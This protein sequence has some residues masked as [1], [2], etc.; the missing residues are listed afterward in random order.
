[1]ISGLVFGSLFYPIAGLEG[2]VFI[3][4]F[5]GLLDIDHLSWYWANKGFT[6][7]PNKIRKW[8]Y[9]N[10]PSIQHLMLHIPELW[11]LGFIILGFIQ[12][13]GIIGWFIHICLDFI[14]AP[15]RLKMHSLIY[16]GQK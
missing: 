5:A 10:T 12:P 16:G 13:W 9:T 2:S 8:Y 14:D 7:N 11:P 1:V 3:F 15:S 6:L 4:V